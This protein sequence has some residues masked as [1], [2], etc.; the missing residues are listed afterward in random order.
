VTGPSTALAAPLLIALAIAPVAMTAPTGGTNVR[1]PR[2]VYLH[3]S[4]SCDSVIDQRTQPTYANAVADARVALWPR[5]FVV[6]MGY[7]R[8]LHPFHYWGKEG[9]QVKAGAGPVDLIVP[10]RYRE[11]ASLMYGDSGGSDGSSIVR[12]KGCSAADSAAP[13]L[14]YAGGFF[15]RQP[16]CLPLKVRTGRASTTVRLSL[17]KRC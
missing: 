12:I 10:P 14:A 15:V 17:G 2:G 6:E 13:W 1:P 11:L 8:Y 4:A 5:S 9:V 3:T 7:Q 16:L